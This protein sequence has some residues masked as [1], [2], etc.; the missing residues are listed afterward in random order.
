MH[1]ATI[2]ELHERL[3]CMG[4]VFHDICVKNKVTYYMI[5][6]TQLGASRHKGFIPWDDDMDF[7]V[8][9]DQFLKCKQCLERDLPSRYKVLTI[10]NSDF[11]NSMFIKILDT[12]TEASYHY[13]KHTNEKY[14]I[15]IDIFPLDKTRND[16]RPFSK[17]WLIYKLMGIDS[18]RLLYLEEL[19]FVN[20]LISYIIKALLAPL[21][22]GAINNFI[23]THLVE[24]KG[25]YIANHGGLYKA[26]EIVSI[27]CYGRPKLYQFEDTTFFG[28]EDFEQY[29]TC[30]YNDW[31]KLPPPNKQHTHLDGILVK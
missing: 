2:K 21:S 28:V 27:K 26:K 14:G 17:N 12:E 5:G 1:N 20:R 13:V 30:L 19:P 9:R 31:R 22:K 25:D 18:Y 7:G 4:K 24:H 11:V 6:G 29:L 15:N 23:L 8:P 3:L 10:E 16:V